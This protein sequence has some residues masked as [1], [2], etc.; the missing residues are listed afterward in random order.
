VTGEYPPTIGGVADHSRLLAG[1]LTRRGGHVHVWCP[2][3]TGLEHEDGVTVHRVAGTWSGADRAAVGRMLRA[4]PAGPV[5]VQWV[6]H[7][8][9]RKSL[10][11]GFC[12]WVWR[13]A[14][15]GAPVEVIVHE[16]FL[17]FG[18]G[19]W[20]QDAAAVV[21]RGMVTMLFAAARRIWVSIPAWEGRIRPWLGGRD[22]PISW[23][24]VPSNITPIEAPEQVADLRRHLLGEDQPLSAPARARAG[25]PPVVA[26]HFGTYGKATREPLLA[27]LERMLARDPSIE[28]VLIGR[29]GPAF[30]DDLCARLPAAGPRVHATG[31]LEAPAVSCHLQ[32][33]DLVVQ[34]YIDGASTRRGTLMAALAHGVPIVTS[35]GRLSEPFWGD[36]HDRSV[37]TVP[38]GDDEG[39]AGAALR[40]AGDADARARLGGAAR[41]LYDA[42]FSIERA[43][44]HLLD[45]RGAA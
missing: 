14:R 42:R 13:L 4:A 30:R 45:G 36:E 10:N 41:R 26:G 18:E 22:V 11:A 1:E 44:A 5:L 23:L 32:A 33:C 17:A 16:P 40:L 15:G 12:H 9:G 20:K 39:M 2:G 8:Y 7:A 38:A 27:T 3:G 28:V 31:A 43:V 24:P 34:P 29:D 25:R 6:P 19:N 37:V 35:V 21:H